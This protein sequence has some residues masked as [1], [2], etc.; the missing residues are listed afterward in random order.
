MFDTHVHSRFSPDGTSYIEDYVKRIDELGLE[1]I[2]F[3]EHLDFIPE[4]GAFEFLDFEAYRA[5]VL[6]FRNAGYDLKFGAE[7]DFLQ[8]VT[9]DITERVKKEK[10]DFLTCS[11]HTINGI[12]VSDKSGPNNFSNI[13]TFRSII[14]Q[15]YIEFKAGL[16]I[17]DFDVV[18][19]AGV[20]KRYLSE[21]HLENHPLKSMIDELDNDIA[22]AT[23]KSDK[24]LEV[25]TSGFF[26]KY[27]NSLP[28]KIFL[29]KYY[30]YGGRQ[31]SLGSDAHCAENLGR[32]FDIAVDMLKEI[33]FTFIYLPWDKENPIIL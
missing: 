5:E 33:G 16:A 23:A 2:G 15:Y 24:L 30:N 22:Y 32:G 25:N 26:A 21:E 20:Y 29:E 18:A 11:I 13:D 10:Y 9:P 28:D 7:I 12:A 19:H 17:K 14:E 3:C 4:C 31:I 1:G 8:R 6:K 27:G